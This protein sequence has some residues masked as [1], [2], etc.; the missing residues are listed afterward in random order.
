MAFLLELWQGSA[1]TR[2]G[3]PGIPESLVL[4]V[5]KSLPN[6]AHKLLTQQDM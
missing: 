6:T 1:G 2:G 3:N 4:Q 5:W